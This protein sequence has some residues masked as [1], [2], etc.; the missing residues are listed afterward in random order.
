MLN[1]ETLINTSCNATNEFK[2][3]HSMKEVPNHYLIWNI[4]R[5]MTKG[6][7]PFCER[8]SYDKRNDDFFSINPSTLLTLKV[9]DDD[10]KMI[11]KESGYSEKKGKICMRYLRKFY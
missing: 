1:N 2:I 4:G 3:I 9:L 10:W 11:M 7:V 6:Y 5:N 8:L